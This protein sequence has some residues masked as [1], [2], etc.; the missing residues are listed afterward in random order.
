MPCLS[1]RA[2]PNLEEALTKDLLQKY[3]IACGFLLQ[4]RWHA[5]LVRQTVAAKLKVSRKGNNVRPAETL[6]FALAHVHDALLWYGF[7]VGLLNKNLAD[8]HR[9]AF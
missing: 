9:P 2:P 5:D 6:G 4:L 1:Y 7:S 3:S 8:I